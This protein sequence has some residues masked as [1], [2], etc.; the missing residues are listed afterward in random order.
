M[1]NH[2]R[3]HSKGQKVAVGETVRFKNGAMA[4]K[5]ANGRFKIVKGPNRK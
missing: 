5:Q 4:K 1:P 3:T 2:Y